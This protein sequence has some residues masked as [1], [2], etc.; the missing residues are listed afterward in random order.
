MSSWNVK[1]PVRIDSTPGGS[2]VVW[3]VVHSNR[4]CGK[5]EVS[6]CP[7]SEFRDDT[8]VTR[9]A[10]LSTT[11]THSIVEIRNVWKG[12]NL[13]N[14]VLVC[15]FSSFQCHEIVLYTHHDTRTRHLLWLPHLQ[16]DVLTNQPTKQQA[17]N[18]ATDSTLTL[19]KLISNSPPPPFLFNCNVL[20]FFWIYHRDWS[21]FSYLF[22][23][24][25]FPSDIFNKL[26]KSI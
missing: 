4:R 21:F 18:Q 8:H 9:N 11:L 14:T 17:A 24:D 22:P 19:L 5:P 13:G 10:R 25:L 3:E 1:Y 6:C 26:H 20:I 15:S 2:T 12:V 23:S 16:R 7:W